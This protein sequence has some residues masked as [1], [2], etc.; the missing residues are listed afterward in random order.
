[1]NE[2]LSWFWFMTMPSSAWISLGYNIWWNQ[3]ISKWMC[4][5]N[6]YRTSSQW[7]VLKGW[8]ISYITTADCPAIF[9]RLKRIKKMVLSILFVPQQGVAV[10]STKNQEAMTIKGLNYVLYH[11]ICSFVSRLKL[12]TSDS[13]LFS[14]VN[15]VHSLSIHT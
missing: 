9:C 14:A 15:P 12:L 5:T 10:W 3:R 13:N 11:T 1:M 6:Y 7:K 2:D 4:L 8:T